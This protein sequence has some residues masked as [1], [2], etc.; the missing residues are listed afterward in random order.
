[1]KEERRKK[2]KGRERFL[3]WGEGGGLDERENKRPMSMQFQ[4][5]IYTYTSESAQNQIQIQIQKIPHWKDS[6]QSKPFA[7]LG[8]GVGQHPLMSLA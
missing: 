8:N 3:V 6:V 1:M 5:D 4:I 2:K 7:S